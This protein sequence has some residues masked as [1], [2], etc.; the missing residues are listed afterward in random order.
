M[1]GLRLWA[2][3]R[4][5]AALPFAFNILFEALHELGREKLLAGVGVKPDFD[6]RIGR[7]GEQLGSVPRF[8]PLPA[9]LLQLLLL[10][11]GFAQLGLKG[12]AFAVKGRIGFVYGLFINHG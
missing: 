9:R 4:F 3:A 2:V 5:L 8:P 7:V 10:L 12:L 6:V 1:T 11:F